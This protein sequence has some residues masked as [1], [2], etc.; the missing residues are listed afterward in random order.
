MPY[1][2]YRAEAC[3]LRHRRPFHRTAPPPWCVRLAPPRRRVQVRGKKAAGEEVQERVQHHAPAPMSVRRDDEHAHSEVIKQDHCDRAETQALGRKDQSAGGR[4]PAEMVDS[5]S[6]ACL[7]LPHRQHR[8]GAR[9]PE[10][11]DRMPASGGPDEDAIV[12]RF[13]VR[14]ATETSAPRTRRSAVGAE[15]PHARLPTRQS[16][17]VQLAE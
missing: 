5:C 8:P 12:P 6:R 7:R 1:A 13:F 16:R 11:T 10:P 15:A 3:L 2:C 9:H 14:S 17:H 4:L